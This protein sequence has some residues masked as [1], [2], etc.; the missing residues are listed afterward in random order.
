[1]CC[2]EKGA[3]SVSVEVKSGLVCCTEKGAS[4]VSVE[5]KSGLVFYTVMEGQ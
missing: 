4:S 5:V 2:T 3:S 1:M